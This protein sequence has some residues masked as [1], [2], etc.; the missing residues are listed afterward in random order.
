MQEG[1]TIQDAGVEGTRRE[2]GRGRSG[3]VVV[4]PQAPRDL[5]A[6][7]NAGRPVRHSPYRAGVHPL[8]SEPVQDQLAEFVVT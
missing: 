5:L 1:G 4:H 8:G 7:V 6:Q 3:A 2:G